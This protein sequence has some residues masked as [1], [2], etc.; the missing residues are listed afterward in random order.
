MLWGAETRDALWSL[1]AGGQRGEPKGDQTAYEQ[2]K[3]LVTSEKGEF[4]QRAEP[5]WWNW[6]RSM[7]LFSGGKPSR[8]W[9]TRGSCLRLEGKGDGRMEDPGLRGWEEG[10]AW[11]RVSGED[12]G[13]EGREEGRWRSWASFQEATWTSRWLQVDPLT[14]SKDHGSC[15]GPLWKVV[16]ERLEKGDA[17]GDGEMPSKVTMTFSCGRGCAWRGKSRPMLLLRIRTSHPPPPGDV[18]PQNWN[19]AG[20]P[21]I[22]LQKLNVLNKH[23]WKW[24][25]GVW[26][27]VLPGVAALYSLGWSLDLKDRL[28]LV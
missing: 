21:Q 9:V 16:D 4:V 14:W 27:Q 12:G 25:F 15:K 7:R 1:R 5:V 26:S 19:P 2:R 6:N 18:C 24:L 17:E 8:V 13:G 22:S 10:S 20:I 3:W 23:T 28:C 11:S